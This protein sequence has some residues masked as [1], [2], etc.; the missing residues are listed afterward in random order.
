M[1]AL[2][3]GSESYEMKSIELQTVKYF[4]NRRYV[5]SSNFIYFWNMIKHYIVRVPAIVSANTSTST[6]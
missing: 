6:I 1:N 3:F 4:G 2:Y 5:A